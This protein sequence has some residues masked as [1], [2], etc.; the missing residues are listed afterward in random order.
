M[1]LKGFYKAC[2]TRS[3][4]ESMRHTYDEWSMHLRCEMTH[5]AFN[6][7]TLVL[8]HCTWVL[9]MFVCLFAGPRELCESTFN[10]NNQMSY[11]ALSVPILILFPAWHCALYVLPEALSRQVCVRCFGEEQEDIWWMIPDL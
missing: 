9:M 5:Y 3:L 6:L 1:S 7:P 2:K 8:F 11:F 4:T 10:C